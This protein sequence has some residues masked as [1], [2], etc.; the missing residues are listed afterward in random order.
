MQ[1]QGGAAP[2]SQGHPERQELGGAGA[3]RSPRHHLGLPASREGQQPSCRH[4]PCN[5]HLHEPGGAG[6]NVSVPS[7]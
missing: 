4:V 1:A 2:A 7:A 6:G 5:T 3:A